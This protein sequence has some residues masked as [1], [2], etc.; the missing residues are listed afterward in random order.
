[1]RSCTRLI[2]CSTAFALNCLAFAQIQEPS[3][4][5]VAIDE[6]AP[7]ITFTDKFGVPRTL[8]SLYKSPQVLVIFAT[9]ASAAEV[10]AIQQSLRPFAINGL[11]SLVVD[12]DCKTERHDADQFWQEQGLL[13]PVRFDDGTLAERYQIDGVPSAAIVDAEGHLRYLGGL[14]RT[15]AQRRTFLDLPTQL[16]YGAPLGARRLPVADP[17]LPHARQC[18]TAR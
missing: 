16:L 18:T 8:D 2:A 1:M 9:E 4:E 5:R 3:A 7:R 10:L 6:P 15:P 14:G 13:L 11:P 12:V 17:A